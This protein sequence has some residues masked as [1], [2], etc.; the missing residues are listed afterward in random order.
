MGNQYIQ[1]GEFLDYTPGSAVAAGE[2]VLLTDRVFVAPRPIAASTLGV[3]ATRGVFNLQKTTGEAWT[4]GQKLYWA[5]GTS[6]V[7]TTASTNK[8]IGYAAAA[9][10]SGDTEGKVLL[11]Q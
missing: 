3:V 9:A 5:A 8:V 10:A 4:Q 11:G 7:T 1:D 6:K 2:V